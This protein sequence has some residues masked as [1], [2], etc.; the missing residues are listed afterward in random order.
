[1][2]NCK[3]EANILK[4]CQHDLPPSFINCVREGTGWLCFHNGITYQTFV[5]VKTDKLIYNTADA[6]LIKIGLIDTDKPL[7]GLTYYGV[8]EV[9]A[10]ED[11]ISG[12]VTFKVSAKYKTPVGIKVTLIPV[13][14]Y[15]PNKDTTLPETPEEPKPENPDPE[16]PNPE[17]P[18]PDP[19]VP[20]TEPDTKPETD[21]VPQFTPE[22]FEA[23][24]KAASP[25]LKEHIGMDISETVEYIKGKVDQTEFYIAKTEIQEQLTG[26][27]DNESL[28]EL[29][30]RITVLETNDNEIIEGFQGPEGPQGPQGPQGEPGLQGPEG[31]TG[32]QGP[33]GTIDPSTLE[34]AKQELTEKINLK[35][36]SSSLTGLSSKID[37]NTA[38]LAKKATKEELATA[39][40]ELTAAINTKAST[41]DL[42][43]AK[44]ELKGLINSGTQEIL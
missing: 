6:D 1:M 31:P 40:Q 10:V 28:D 7:T 35:A 16:Q 17:T 27:A 9:E 30:A 18:K 14:F 22:W 41:S 32:P 13:K 38:E 29:R 15:L 39:K 44:V 19:E 23:Y 20:P 24:L 3:Y 21:Q 2:S 26:K 36:D 37:T 42:Q 33:A 4:E 43:D 5:V 34:T 8:K 25:L 12:E 11:S